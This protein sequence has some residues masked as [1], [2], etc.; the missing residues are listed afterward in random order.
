M[1]KHVLKNTAFV[2][3]KRRNAGS[4]LSPEL[5][6]TDDAGDDDDDDEDDEAEGDDVLLAV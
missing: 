1:R 2:L 4:L 6:S 3:S 5:V